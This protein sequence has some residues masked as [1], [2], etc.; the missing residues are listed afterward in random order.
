MIFL[1]SSGWK[2]HEKSHSFWWGVIIHHPR[3]DGWNLVER[4]GLGSR[5][6]C[7]SIANSSDLGELEGVPILG[8]VFFRFSRL[9]LTTT[10][11]QSFA[12][13]LGEMTHER[14][15]PEC[16]ILFELAVPPTND[17]FMLLW[18]IDINGR[19]NPLTPKLAVGCLIYFGWHDPG[20]FS[21]FDVES[22]LMWSWGKRWFKKGN[23]P[24]I[25]QPS[26]RP[27]WM[28][29]TLHMSKKNIMETKNFKIA[30]YEHMSCWELPFLECG[31]FIYRWRLITIR[32]MFWRHPR[33][34]IQYLGM[35]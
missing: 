24:K 23:P 31:S 21:N 35:I 16:V 9:Q 34:S 25:H 33:K 5:W 13:F 17:D 19:P 18:Y 3:M 26:R 2:S 12:T 15:P 28:W 11:N 14:I 22:I 8:F 30:Y 29:E 20:A 4:F 10:W 27:T 32:S 6:N 7:R 1:F